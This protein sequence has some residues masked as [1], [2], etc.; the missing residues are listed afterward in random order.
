MDLSQSHD[1]AVVAAEFESGSYRPLPIGWRR[2][3]SGVYRIAFRGPDGLVYKV[4]KNGSWNTANEAKVFQYWKDNNYS[5]APD[6]RYWP[7]ANV[8]VMPEYKVLG[9]STWD[10]SVSIRDQVEAIQ[11]D[12]EVTDSH[13]DNLALDGDRVVVI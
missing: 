7:D 8:M 5:F 9:T 11:Y 1:N 4:E 10:N 3:G 12:Y 6:F 2:L 13:E